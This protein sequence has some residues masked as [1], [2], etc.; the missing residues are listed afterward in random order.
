MCRCDLIRE[1]PRGE[2]VW[3]GITAQQREVAR[4]CC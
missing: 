2:D 1:V 4:L 3:W